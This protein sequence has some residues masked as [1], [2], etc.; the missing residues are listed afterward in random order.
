MSPT[1][2][3]TAPPRARRDEDYSGS[4]KRVSN[5]SAPQR[6][7]QSAVAPLERMTFD[8]FADSDRIQEVNS[9]GVLATTSKPCLPRKSRVSGARIAR[10]VSAL[11]RD[12]T[13]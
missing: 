8:H 12:T 9:A 7:T 4:R 2:C 13:A 3:Q 10:T 5:F 6:E 11:K 1:S